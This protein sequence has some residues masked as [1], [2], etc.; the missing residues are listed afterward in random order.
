[1]LLLG[2]DVNALII[3]ITAFGAAAAI[4]VGHKAV[5]N[6]ISAETSGR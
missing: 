4:H 3:L 5:S 6:T 1:M 2:L